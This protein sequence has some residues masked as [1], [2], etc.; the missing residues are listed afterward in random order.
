MS[1]SYYYSNNILVACEFILGVI[2][3]YFCIQYFFGCF[4]RT[5]HCAGSQG[6]VCD[7]VTEAR[8]AF[9]ELLCSWKDC[10]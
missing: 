4:S 10:S 3:I 9:T 2:G 5:R 6:C 1:L 8:P 7:S